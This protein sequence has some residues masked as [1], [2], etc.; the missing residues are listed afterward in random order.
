MARKR[1][2]S[3]VKKYAGKTEEE[4]REWGEEFGKQ[5]EKLGESFGSHMERR[6]KKLERKYRS[7]WFETF[8]FIGPL[9]K[10]V[11][12]I[13]FLAIGIFILNFIN[14]Y[15]SN[16]FIFMLSDFLFTYL[17]LFFWASLFFGYCKYFSRIHAKIY[18]TISPLVDSLNIVFVI[19]IL[20]S[21]FIMIGAYTMTD[22]IENFSHFL[23][24]NLFGLFIL[25][26]II[27]Y[28]IEFAKRTKPKN[29]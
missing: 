15:L 1:K 28:V 3:K 13:F 10:S 11:I 16:S 17:P 25:F 8:G 22:I 26:A 7:W 18:W 27:G 14:I 6:G 24:D 4:W 21:I 12:G 29:F 20:M 2:T 19:W 9:I 23:I 5:M